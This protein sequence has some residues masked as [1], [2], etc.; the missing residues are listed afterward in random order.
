M[1]KE[2]LAV[3]KFHKAFGL[4]IA[5]KPKALSEEA[6]DRR[7]RLMAEELIELTAA[8]KSGD[9]T[10][11]AD[12]ICDLL[13]VTYGTAIEAGLDIKPLFEEVQR[14]NMTKVR[15]SLNEFGKWIKPE[16]YDPPHLETLIK[17]QLK[18]NL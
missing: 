4:P 14:S 8:M 2:Q 3:R 16:T 10:A 1:N 12:G 17:K 9:L 7:R 11:I 5:N 18:T 6:V 13:Y 15:G